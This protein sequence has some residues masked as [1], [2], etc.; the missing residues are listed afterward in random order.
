MTL[1]STDTSE[2]SIHNY[3]KSFCKEFLE[4]RQLANGNSKVRSG[5]YHRICQTSNSLSLWLF[6]KW[7]IMDITRERNMLDWRGNGLW[8]EHTKSLKEFLWLRCLATCKL[9]LTLRAIFFSKICS[10]SF[11]YFHSKL[12]WIGGLHQFHSISTGSCDKHAVH[13]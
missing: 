13:V 8:I 9:T 6:I 12:F 3:P 5:A 11:E 4:L 10:C 7:P 1:H 2:N